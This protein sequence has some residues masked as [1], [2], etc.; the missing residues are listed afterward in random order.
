MRKVL[1]CLYALAAGIVWGYC[2]TGCTAVD[3][4]AA[5]AFILAPGS[6]PVPDSLKA[7]LIA[8]TD[9]FCQQEG[10]PGVARLTVSHRA[11]D[12]VT[13]VSYLCIGEGLE[14][15]LEIGGR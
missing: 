5:P 3:A 1:W 4:N 6:D 12:Q 11:K 13:A 15:R 14:H 7:H 10:F 9:K 2:W 8:Q